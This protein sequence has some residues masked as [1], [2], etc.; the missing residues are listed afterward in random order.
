MNKLAAFKKA[1]WSHYRAHGRDMPWRRDHRAY[2]VV[3]SEIMLQQTQVSRV[4]PKFQSFVRRFPDW[5]H[6]AR[7]SVADVLREW[8][9]LGY[10]RRALWLKR[11]AE[12]VVTSPTGEL[13]RTY[14]DLRELPGIGPNTAGSIL[15]FA[16]DIPHPFIETNIRSAYIHFFFKD[17]RNKIQDTNIMRLIEETLK[18]TYIQKRAREWHYALMDYGSHLKSLHPNPS[19]K[20]ARHVRQSP[21]KGSNREQRSRLLKAIMAGPFVPVKLS[22]RDRANLAALEREGFIE[23][24]GKNYAIRI[25]G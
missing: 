8:S 10:N 2:Y 11:I 19:R 21:F 24:R 5:A 14:E 17:T 20:S 13:P 3:V 18:D 15:A 23:K 9:G 22:A 4:V 6:L 7:A 1:V 25:R 16:S 12:H